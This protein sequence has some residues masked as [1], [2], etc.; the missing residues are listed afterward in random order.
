MSNKQTVARA[1]N[2][3]RPEAFTITNASDGSELRA[4]FI[5]AVSADAGASVPDDPEFADIMTPEP[6]KRLMRALATGD[7]EAARVVISD[8]GYGMGSDISRPQVEA[9][10]G[11]AGRPDAV[12]VIVS[13]AGQAL[14]SG[15]RAVVVRGIAYV[16]ARGHVNLFGVSPVR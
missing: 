4:E 14:W 9:L 3:S 15:C 1:E 16:H 7:A 11:I 6:G 13:Q 12:P 2:G 5:G 10:M 8:S